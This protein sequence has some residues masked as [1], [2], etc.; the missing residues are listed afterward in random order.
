MSA[1]KGVQ[2]KVSA[3]TIN[4]LGLQHVD[5]LV[6]VNVLLGIRS[7]V[8]C[9]CLR[10]LISDCYLLFLITDLTSRYREKVFLDKPCPAGR[11]PAAPVSSAA[12]KKNHLIEAAPFGRLDQM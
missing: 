2:E 9:S 11:S 6:H 7:F 3:S 8:N 10:S 5:K 1:R 12:P 4:Q